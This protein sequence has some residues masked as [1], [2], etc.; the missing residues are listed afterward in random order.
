MS[1]D[2][3]TTEIYCTYD[4][5]YKHWEQCDNIAWLEKIIKDNLGES[6]LYDEN[7]KYKFIPKDEYEGYK[8]SNVTGYREES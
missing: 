2:S 7:E 3:W 8:R 5:I 6:Y 4:A 1:Y